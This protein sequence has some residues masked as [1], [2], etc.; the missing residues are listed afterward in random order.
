MKVAEPVSPE[1]LEELKKLL[2]A[3]KFHIIRLKGAAFYI[4][5]TNKL[6]TYFTRSVKTAEVNSLMQLLINPDFFTK[7]CKNTPERAG[8]IAHECSHIS[9]G[10]LDRGVGIQDMSRYQQAADYRINGDLVKAG[11]TLPAGGL[12]DP[13][14]EGKS[15]EEIYRELPPGQTKPNGIGNDLGGISTEEVGFPDPN[16]PANSNQLKNAVR[17]LLNSAVMAAKA[18]AG[19]IPGEVQ[20]KLNELNNPIIPFEVILRRF[21]T[22]LEKSGK[23]WKMPNW[24]FQPEFYLPSKTKKEVIKSAAFVIDTSMS[25]TGEIFDQA[26]SDVANVFKSLD[27]EYI[28]IIMF[29]TVVQAEY[30]IKSFKEFQQKVIFK[31]GGGTEINPAL[32]R[33][34]ELNPNVCVILTDGE[35]FTKPATITVPT[36]WAIFNN[37]TFKAPF[38]KTYIYELRNQNR[39]AS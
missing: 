34:Q 13:K 7:Q 16:A 12:L 14:F 35:L 31:G 17:D 8:L 26:V 27:M 36:V 21:V 22:G 10:H 19:H 15:T 3:A 9:Y 33:I 20:A 38:G 18:S 30:R 1:E 32:K 23:S 37:P 2:T 11:I 39:K 5:I 24:K 4:E 25:T 29:D 6:K 28:D